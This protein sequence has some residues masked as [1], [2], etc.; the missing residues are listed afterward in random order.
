MKRREYGRFLVDLCNK[1][2]VSMNDIISIKR[3]L[4]I[5]EMLRVMELVCK[6]DEMPK[7]FLKKAEKH[8]EILLNRF[9]EPKEVADIVFF[10]FTRKNLFASKQRTGFYRQVM[11]QILH[12]V[13]RV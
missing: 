9:A 13:L 5:Q 12:N 10:L 4:D 8:S 1:K 6:K 11:R 7:L 3:I 2:C